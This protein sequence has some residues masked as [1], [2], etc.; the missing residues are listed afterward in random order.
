MSQGKQDSAQSPLGSASAKTADRPLIAHLHV[1]DARRAIL[2]DGNGRSGVRF[3]DVRVSRQ[4]PN[5]S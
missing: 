2:N 3:L 1:R 5:R 4:A